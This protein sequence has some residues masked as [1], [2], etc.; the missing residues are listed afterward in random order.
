VVRHFSKASIAQKNNDRIAV[1]LRLAV[2][3]FWIDVGGQ[4]VKAARA[5]GDAKLRWSAAWPSA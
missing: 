5:N 3:S 4:E 2:A 1:K